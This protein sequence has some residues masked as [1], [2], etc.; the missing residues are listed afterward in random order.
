MSQEPEVMQL[1]RNLYN[2]LTD[3]RMPKKA[4]DSQQSQLRQ[5]AKVAKNKKLLLVI[6]G[7][8]HANITKGFCTD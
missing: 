5:L 2:Q 1:Q 6:D 4:T 7:K 8:P 3:D